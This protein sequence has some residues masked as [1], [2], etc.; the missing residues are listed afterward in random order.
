MP[1]PSFASV[2]A[3][4][5]AQPEAS[6]PVLERVRAAIRKALPTATELISYQIPAYKLPVGWVI[7]FAGF[8]KHYSVFP[9]QSALV[10]HFAEE[11]LPYESNGKGTI[12]FPLSEPVP[13]GLIGRIAKF[14][15]KEL[16]TRRQSKAPGK[17]AARVREA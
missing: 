10:A 4:I 13:A 5:A 15:V 9:A 3:Y 17:S 11:L 14:R 2:D 12:R 8:K 1:R 6:R 16:T 7:Y